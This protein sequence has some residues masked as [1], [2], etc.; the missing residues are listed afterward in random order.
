MK[1]SLKLEMVNGKITKN[2]SS[3]EKKRK[4][5]CQEVPIEVDNIATPFQIKD[6]FDFI[7]YHFIPDERQLPW[8]LFYDDFGDE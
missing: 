6:K 3:N 1:A 8:D 7:T 5:T 4:I 2:H